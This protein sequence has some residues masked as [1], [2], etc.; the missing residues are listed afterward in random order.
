MSRISSISEIRSRGS[1]IRGMSGFSDKE[2]Y[3]IKQL[4]EDKER[5]K[6]I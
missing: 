6:R 5:E 2:V 1:W 3:T 4:V